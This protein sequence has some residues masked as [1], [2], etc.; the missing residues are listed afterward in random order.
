MA[1][2]LHSF[3]RFYGVYDVTNWHAGLA[4]PFFLDAE[5]N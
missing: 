5:A 4:T 3:Q 2:L 1:D